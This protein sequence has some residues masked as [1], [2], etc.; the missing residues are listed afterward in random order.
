MSDHVVQWNKELRLLLD[1]MQARPSADWTAERERVR[2]L[3]GLIAARQP[4]A[5]GAQG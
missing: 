1:Q 3:T 4:V 5:A 2:V